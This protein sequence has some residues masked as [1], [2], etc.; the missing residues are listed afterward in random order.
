MAGTAEVV[1]VALEEEQTRALLQE[2][3]QAYRM[4]LPEVLLTGLAGAYG[5]WKGREGV[6]IDLEGHGREE[7]G[8]GGLDVTRTVGWFTTIYPVVLRVEWRRGDAGRALREVKEQMRRIPQRGVGY[9]LLRYVRGEE[10]V[11]RRLR[12]RAAEL[13]FNY[14]GQLDQVLEEKGVFGGAGESAGRMHSAQGRR[15]H[16]LEVNAAVQGGR[17]QMAWTYSGKLHDR[18]KV[19]ELAEKTVEKLEELIAH[20]R[21]A[22]AGGYTPSDFPL[23]DLDDRELEGLMTELKAGQ[24]AQA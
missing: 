12:R 4:Q 23:V 7:M 2:V 20:C 6:V 24:D 8:G 3:P 1:R 21:S 9:G 16:E 15:S 11:E 22:E 17:L 10:E 19:E 14:L 18:K 5:E 13:S